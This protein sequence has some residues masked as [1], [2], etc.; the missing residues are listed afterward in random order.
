LS[1][2]Y[3]SNGIHIRYNTDKSLIGT[4]R[5]ASNNIHMGMEPSRRDDLT[6]VG[7]ML[8]Y[9]IKGSL[10]WQGLK[11]QKGVDHLQNIGEIK[12]CTSLDKLCSDLPLCFKNYLKYCLKLKF[13][14]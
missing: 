10:P 6:S 2:K 13:D 1:K 12:L 14:E 5:Y 9:F 8:I 11:K 7:Y 3:I 4:A